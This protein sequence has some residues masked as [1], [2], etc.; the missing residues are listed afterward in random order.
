MFRAF[1]RSLGR[2]LPVDLATPVLDLACGE[3]ALLAFLRHR[4][5]TN[6]AGCDISPENVTIC[7]RL[8]LGFV[9]QADALELDRMAGVGRYGAVFALDML[10]HLPKPRAAAF[11]DAVRRRLLPGGYV[12]VQTLNMGSHLGWYHRYADVTHEFGLTESSAAALFT[13]AGFV[14]NKIQIRPSWNATTPLGYLREVY[15]RAVHR[16]LWAAEGAHRPRI[17]TRDLL[18]RAEVE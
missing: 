14:A 2:W 10:E 6:L 16:L 17:P 13:A 7:H 1:E 18:I 11:L 8:G 5:Y 3:G 12:V 4:G 15:L 9:V